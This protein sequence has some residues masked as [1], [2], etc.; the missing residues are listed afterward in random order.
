MSEDDK[1][2]RSPQM[3]TQKLPI[4]TVADASWADVTPE[5]DEN[6]DLYEGVRGRRVA[7]YAIDF[8]IILLLIVGLWVVAIGPVLLSFGLLHA[9]VVAA[10]ALL[11][12]AY[13]ALCIGGPW[14]ATVGMRVMGLR[15]VGVDGDAPGYAQAAIQTGVFLVTAAMTQFLVVLISFFNDQAR[16]LHDYLAGTMVVNDWA[17]KAQQQDPHE[18]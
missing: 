3:T 9:P 17:L 16:C 8:I 12:F 14:N 2:G 13:H 6:P 1:D 15:V 7:A 10:T 11:P 18:I 5:W 4:E